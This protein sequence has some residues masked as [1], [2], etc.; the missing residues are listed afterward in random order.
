MFNT[1]FDGNCKLVKNSHRILCR[2]L[3]KCK[4]DKDSNILTLAEGIPNNV[5]RKKKDVFNNEKKVKAENK[6][7]YI[8]STNNTKYNKQAMKNKSCIYETKKYSRLEKKIFKEL[9][10]VDFLKN[11]RMIS[12]KLYKKII[13]KKYGLRFTLPLLGVLLLSAFVI[14][15]VIL[16]SVHTKDFWGAIG[17]MDYLKTLNGAGGS[18]NSLLKK[19]KDYLPSWLTVC[20]EWS[21]Q[22]NHSCNE[23]CTLTN[24]FGII[25]Y[26]VPFFIIGVT[27]ISLLIYYH[28][29]VKKFEK[30]KFRKR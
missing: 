3:A 19:A 30:I 21:R 27:F 13:R 22:T 11:N 16:G 23:L 12:D 25:V 7:L 8:S 28:K 20:A 6:S 14:I 2:S 15:D 1:Y 24:L 10:Y 17:L 5:L 4:N 18:L 26:F 9:D 29:K